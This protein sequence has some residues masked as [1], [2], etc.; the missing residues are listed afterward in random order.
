M[1]GV[2]RV[3][4]PVLEDALE[5]SIAL[6]G[7]MDSR[8]YGRT[9]T[10]GL[11]DRRITSMLMLTGL[12]GATIG[13]Y[14]LLDGTASRLAG[15]PILV[16]GMGLATLGLRRA[17]RRIVKSVYRRDVWHRTEWM[18]TLLSV[19]S[20]AMFVATGN[21]DV[22]YPAV[23]PPVWPSIS[24]VGLIAIAMSAAPAWLSPPA[25]EVLD[26]AG[27]TLDLVPT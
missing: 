25:E 16:L 4:V 3:L 5:R 21:V 8:G 2:D 10:V 12:S 18:V 13:V 6:A 11:R 22:M 19:F 7:A 23:Q 26:R 14:G 27:E 9:G 24:G 1:R 15:L 17:G 20:A